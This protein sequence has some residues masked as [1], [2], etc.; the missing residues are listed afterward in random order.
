MFKMLQEAELRSKA[1]YIVPAVLSERVA[2]ML[3]A[4][5]PSDLQFFPT[6]LAAGQGA[7]L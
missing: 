7:A 4:H 1:G 2:A 3:S 6:K 5:T